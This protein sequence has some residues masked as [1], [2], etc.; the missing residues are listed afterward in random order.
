MTTIISG[1]Y[2]NGYDLNDPTLNPVTNTGSIGYGT[3]ENPAAL[4]GENVAAWTITN[5]GTISGGTG[6]IGVDLLAGGSVTNIATASIG[7]YWGVVIQG[8][9]GGVTNAGTIDSTVGLSA[10]YLEHGGSVTN[11]MG[12]QILA[13]GDGITT[14]GGTADVVNSGTITAGSTGAGVDL[15]AGGSATNDTG[16]MI[17]GEWGVSIQGS[18]NGSVWNQGVIE[19]GVQ[20]GIFLSGGTV[21]NTTGG[22]ISGN[23]GIAIFDAAG[24]VTNQAGGE[25]SGQLG[26]DVVGAAG[27]VINGGTII[28]T[29][30]TAVALS[31]GY[32]NQVTVD[33]G[34]VFTGTVDGGNVV[35]SAVVS[36][37]ELAAGITKGSLLGFGTKFVDFGS[38][39]FDPN[40]SWILSGTAT[41]LTGPEITGFVTGDT[42]DLTG[43]T[44][45]KLRWDQVTTAGG[46]LSVT[47]GASVIASLDI[48]GTQ[49]GFALQGDG[50]GG[51]DIVAATQ[52]VLAA[53][54]TAT[55]SQVAVL[56][57][58]GP[59]FGSDALS[60]TLES[61]ARFAPGA[62]TLALNDGSLIYAPG[63]ITDANAGVDTVSYNVTDTVTGTVI[64]E[65]QTVTL[66]TS[67]PRPRPS[68]GTLAAERG[69]RRVIGPTSRPAPPA[70]RAV[71]I[72][73]SSRAGPAPFPGWARRA[74]WI[75]WA[76]SGPWTGTSTSPT[77]LRSAWTPSRHCSSTAA[78]PLMPAARRPSRPRPAV[79]A[80]ASAS[81]APIRPGR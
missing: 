72:P 30:G 19:G 18:A 26:V 34:A 74:R 27:T 23:W 61:D 4:Q 54:P 41:G 13:G 56:G 68:P 81:W 10:V 2:P 21:T 43:Q 24:S 51:T 46:T 42:I 25:I 36:T 67:D 20:S 52:L 45:L 7:G 38:I 53:S 9:T 22:Q 28:G 76:A 48:S 60:V 70:R 69:Q 50:S 31:S 59:D 49:T 79:P 6:G 11:M 33:P 47:N 55:N 75:S 3:S 37:L 35:G 71:P 32:V 29:Q 63:L 66:S 78:A 12:G 57:T 58:I 16:G 77:T 62:S 8:S 17:S 73:P 40:A 39:V 65:T 80:P 64:A 44:G 5:E 14:N 15:I 1:N